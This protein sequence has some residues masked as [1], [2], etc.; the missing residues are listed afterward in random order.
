MTDDRPAPGHRPLPQ[1]LV[2]R[3]LLESGHVA[4]IGHDMAEVD[5]LGQRLV[6]S[7]RQGA[8]LEVLVLFDPESDAL[9][10]RINQRLS[11]LTLDEA[12]DPVLS[13]GPVQVWVLR[14]QTAAQSRQLLTLARMIRDFPAVNLRLIALVT[15][16][17]AEALLSGALGRTFLPWHL[18]APPVRLANEEGPTPVQPPAGL[19][20]ARQRVPLPQAPV[21][22]RALM[23][24]VRS[25]F[26]HPPDPALVAT[27]AVS[28]LVVSLLMRCSG[29]AG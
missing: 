19:D 24:K 7:L 12:R 4:L 25:A 6:Q 16:G 22:R 20:P 5:G 10:G 11:P 15:P 21:E 9:I 2:D 17:Q 28:L 14:A 23:D 3:I 8:G 26:R 1:A 18:S 13:H 27:L 29:V